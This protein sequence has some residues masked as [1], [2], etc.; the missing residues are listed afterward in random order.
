MTYT[1]KDKHEDRYSI[2]KR[3]SEHSRRQQRCPNAEGRTI[4]KKNNSRN[5]NTKK[6]QN[7][8]KFKFI[9]RNMEK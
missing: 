1:W 8:G 5:N 9:R 4:D 6:T 2:K 7:N 3:S